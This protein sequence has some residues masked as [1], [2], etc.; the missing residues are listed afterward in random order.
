MRLGLK[1]VGTSNGPIS[2]PVK[3]SEDGSVLKLGDPFRETQGRDTEACYAL[4]I[5][6]STISGYS[7]RECRVQVLYKP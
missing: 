5:D 6:C 1:V 3:D 7:L 2:R 4:S